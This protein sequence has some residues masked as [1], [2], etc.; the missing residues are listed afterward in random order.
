M[1]AGVY[2]ILKANCTQCHIYGQRDPAGWGSVLDVSRMIDGD[3]V[4]PG[5]L[6]ESRLWYRV[7][8]R[9]DMPF[10]GTR[11][12]PDEKGQIRDW[13]LGMQ[14]PY[15]RPRKNEDILDVLVQD[16]RRV[17]G[18]VNDVRYLS[19]AHFVDEGRTKEEL[20]VLEGVVNVMLNSLSRRP[21]LI[22]VEAA[23]PERT[24][25]RFRISQLG[26]NAA[27]WDEVVK[28]YPYCLQS[29]VQAHQNLYDRLD[30]EAPY[31]RGD[32]FIDTAMISPLYER[33]V[34]LGANL[35][36]LEAQIGF[37]IDQN[38]RDSKVL[39][40]GFG[41]S[42]VSNNERMIERHDVGGGNYFWWSYDFA[43]RFEQSRVTE[44]PLG[45]TIVTGN[46]FQNTF[47]QAGGQAIFS[48][49]NNMQ[50][51]FLTDAV[52]TFLSK[53]PTAIVA[54]QRRR[55]GAVQNAISCMN[56][57]T[58]SGMLKPKTYD[59][60][61]RYVDEHRGDFNADEIA[62][63]RQIYPRNA[64]AVLL[65][66]D[67]RF[68]RSI[69]LLGT[70]VTSTMQGAG[71][72]EWDP[73]A[74]LVGQ[75]ESKLGLRGGSTELGISLDQARALFRTDRRSANNEDALPLLITDPL[76]TREEWFCRFREVIGQDVLRGVNF[77]DGS[78][79]DPTLIQFCDTLIND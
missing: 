53:A 20:A 51:Y 2:N 72:I 39:R 48:L 58:E 25:F 50:G 4:V 54:D 34:D 35:D 64:E 38:V 10:D 68:K 44:K 70:T 73:W 57:H 60:V 6:E 63:I 32:W 41:M 21:N 43:N 79:E 23:D 17:G 37:D 76:V 71:V 69:N 40:I 52:G 14:R 8:V 61:Q 62:E 30:T 24:I 42:G 19:F 55:D 36:E 56:C 77:C 29:N 45:P 74:N 46:A 78:F 33:L 27:D 15:N 18:N 3:I 26:W 11:L 75:Y 66:D 13:I 12:T 59:D 28:F 22:K 1:P 7:A 31:V 47:N 5:S 49:P 16:S 9:S 65:R 67:A